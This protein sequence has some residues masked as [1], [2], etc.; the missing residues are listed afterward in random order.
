MGRLSGSRNRL[1]T[2]LAFWLLATQ[3]PAQSLPQQ[4]V[5]LKYEVEPELQSCPSLAE[6]RVIVAQQLGYDP[7]RAGSPLGLEVRIQPTENGIEGNIVWDISPHK[8]LGERRFKS[9]REECREMMATIGF[10]VAVQI[11][12]MATERATET[13]S[14]PGPAEPTKRLESVSSQAPT[15]RPASVAKLTLGSFE[16]RQPSG[17]LGTRWQVIA[18]VGP[19]AGFGIGPGPVALGRLFVAL[20]SGWL[21][22]EAGAEATLPSESRESYGGGFR[23]QLAL[24]TLAICGQKSSLSACGLTKF[25]RLRADG[26]GVDRPASP[27]GMVAQIGLRLMYELE[28]HENFA[29]LGHVDALYLVTP[30]TVDLNYM[31]VWSMPRLSTVAGIDLE[32][33][34]Q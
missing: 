21:G 18:G 5:D 26:L 7:Y 1:A 14:A 16:V 20:R 19:A 31:A 27:Q 12:L 28:L 15:N 4:F 8:S 32:V 9:R 2:G 23:H 10:V 17:P 3:A 25:G 30:W 6:F 34:L 13:P 24:A 22:L 33:R 29:L 11:Q